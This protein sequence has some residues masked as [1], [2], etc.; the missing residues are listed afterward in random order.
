MTYTKFHTLTDV[1]L[2][3][4]VQTAG[5]HSPLIEELAGRFERLVCGEGDA[6]AKTEEFEQRGS[7]NEN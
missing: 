4:L 6:A 2:L 3:S 5:L 1:E 7:R